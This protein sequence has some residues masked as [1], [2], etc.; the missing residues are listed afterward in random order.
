MSESIDQMLFD[1]Q[2]AWYHDHFPRDLVPVSDQ[3]LGKEPFPNNSLNQSDAASC[4]SLSKLSCTTA[5]AVLLG[6][7]PFWQKSKVCVMS[8]T[9]QMEINK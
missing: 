5:C 8:K 2:Q 4:H 6:S 9:L 3:H 1:L 7:A